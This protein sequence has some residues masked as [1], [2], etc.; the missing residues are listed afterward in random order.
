M[1]DFLL[2]KYLYIK[3]KML[4]KVIYLNNNGNF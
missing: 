2:N 3:N 4:F 1:L